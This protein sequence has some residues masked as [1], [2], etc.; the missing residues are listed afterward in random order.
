MFTGTLGHIYGD[1]NLK[2]FITISYQINKGLSELQVC[3]IVIRSGE[4][5]RCRGATFFGAPKTTSLCVWFAIEILCTASFQYLFLG[6][7]IF[8]LEAA[9]M[10]A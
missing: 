5:A 7:D 6:A 1:S 10:M 3:N 2:P 4:E 9:R 8:E